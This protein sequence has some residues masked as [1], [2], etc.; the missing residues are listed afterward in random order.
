MVCLYL[1]FILVIYGRGIL[2]GHVRAKFFKLC[3]QPARKIIE[4]EIFENIN[5]TASTYYY[6]YYI[7]R[8]YQ[9]GKNMLQCDNN[10][11]ENEP[12]IGNE[13]PMHIR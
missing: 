4:T 9:F 7:G 2:F 1:F 13:D 3:Y 10:I 5:D 12:Y 11:K 6:Y 8:N